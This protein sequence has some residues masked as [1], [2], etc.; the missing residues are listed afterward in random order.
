M[1]EN[2][3]LGK[4]NTKLVARAVKAAGRF[5]QIDDGEET[6]LFTPF[7]SKNG[8]VALLYDKLAMFTDDLVLLGDNGSVAVNYQHIIT[9]LSSSVFEEN[10]FLRKF[11]E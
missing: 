9:P 4:V 3:E 6:Y 10:P 11:S 7:A 8:Y 1:K 5:V 2:T